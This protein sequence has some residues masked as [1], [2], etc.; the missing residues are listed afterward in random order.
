MTVITNDIHIAALLRHS[1]IKVVVTGGV[2]YPENFILNGEVTDR[3]IANLNVKKAFIATPALHPEKG[4]THFDDT[5]VSAKKSMIRAAKEIFV[6]ADHSKLGM[7]S[8]IYI[9]KNG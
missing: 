5:L 6:V 4:L 1:K 3:T 2:L 7:L 9:W 8:V